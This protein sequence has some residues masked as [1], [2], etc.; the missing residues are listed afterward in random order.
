MFNSSMKKLSN[1]HSSFS[2]TDTSWKDK[3]SHNVQRNSQNGQKPLKNVSS[4]SIIFHRL[5]SKTNYF[6][7]KKTVIQGKEVAYIQKF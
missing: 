4:N 7:P 6:R 3:S 2:N 5:K 1:L